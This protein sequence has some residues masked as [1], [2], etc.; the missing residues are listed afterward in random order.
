[1]KGGSA[2]P[3]QRIQ[4]I[5]IQGKIDMDLLHHLFRIGKPVGT[6]TIGGNRNRYVEYFSTKTGQCNDYRTFQAT[7]SEEA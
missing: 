4:V 2:S 1:M 3:L 6:G 7:Y 5:Y